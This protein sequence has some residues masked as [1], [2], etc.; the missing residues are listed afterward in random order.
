MRIIVSDSSCL[1]DLR[2]A[3]L[4]GAFMAT[5]YKVL[6]PDTLFDDELIR[7]SEDEKRGLLDDGLIIQ[8]IPGDGVV[9]AQDVKSLYPALSWH[10]CFAFV[11]AEKTPNCI[12]LAGDGRLRKVADKHGVEVHGVLW[13]VD[14]MHRATTATVSEIVSAL[15]LFESDPAVFRLPSRELNG[16]LIRYRAM[17][18]RESTR[19]AT[20]EEE[21]DSLPAS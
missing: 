16:F 20:G 21:I 9:R 19:E 14:E 17:A 11:L 10:D 1:I 4:L 8:E 7:F 18:E 15:A 5:P 6:I 12:L 13:A 2:K 3:S